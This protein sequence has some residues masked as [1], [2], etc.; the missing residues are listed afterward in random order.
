ME[1]PQKER[2][3]FEIL[4]YQASPNLQVW[5]IKAPSIMRGN[6]KQKDEKPMTRGSYSQTNL[7]LFSKVTV[8]TFS[9]ILLIIQKKDLFSPF[10]FF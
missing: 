9:N 5:P 4:K 10:V 1:N 6:I 3:L 8:L 2:I 7:R